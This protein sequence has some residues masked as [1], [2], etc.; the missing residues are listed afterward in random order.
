MGKVGGEASAVLASEA[1]RNTAENHVE[2]I[3]G[4]GGRQES[5]HRGRG[6]GMTGEFSAP[7]CTPL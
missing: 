5:G 1:Q 6:S 4:P 3:T 2:S 7:N